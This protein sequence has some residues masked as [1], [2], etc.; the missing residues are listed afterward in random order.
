MMKAERSDTLV[1]FGATGDLARKKILP[2]LYRMVQRGTLKEPVVGVALEQWSVQQM[3]DRAYE[4]GQ[5]LNVATH[6]EFDDVIDPADSR[7]WITMAIEASTSGRDEA[8]PRAR[9]PNI[10]TW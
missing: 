2:S 10:D 7:R 5:A 4:H 9:R 8:E 1:L 6:F 3:I